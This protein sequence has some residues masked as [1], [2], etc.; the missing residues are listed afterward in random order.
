MLHALTTT[1]L[2]ASVGVGLEVVF[3]GLANL[4]TAGDVRLTGHS[5][6]WMFPIYATAY[7]LY[8]LSWPALHALPWAARGVL[9]VVAFF[10]VEYA[11]GWLLRHVVGRCPWEDGYLRARWVGLHV[12]RFDRRRV[13]LH[14]HRLVEMRGDQ[15]LVRRAEI[16]APR[17][18]RR[19]LDLALVIGDQLERVVVGDAREGRQAA[20]QRG[21]VALQHLQLLAAPLQAALHDRADKA[22]LKHQIVGV[23][24]EGHLFDFSA[25]KVGPK[26]YTLPKLSIPL[27]T[28]SWPVW[29][30]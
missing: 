25:R 12:E 26:Q 7:P 19:A 2:L 5:Y 4:R 20:L 8:T 16:L 3:T 6:L 9:Y 17:Q 18:R 1:Y 11:S 30:R 10:L 13:L 21:G 27:S 14:K 15:C 24:G 23:G 22:L 28:Y 29:A